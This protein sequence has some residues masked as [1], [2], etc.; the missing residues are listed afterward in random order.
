MEKKYL[1]VSTTIS[2]LAVIVC[3]PVLNSSSTNFIWEFSH[4][5]PQEGSL[6]T[7]AKEKMAHLMPL[8]LFVSGSTAV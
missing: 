6:F 4:I 3:P 2:D 8:L 5:V 7:S 1:C